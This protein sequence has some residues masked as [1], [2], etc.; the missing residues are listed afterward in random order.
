MFREVN[1]KSKSE[2]RTQEVDINVFEGLMLGYPSM[3]GHKGD[4]RQVLRAFK[5][6]G[7]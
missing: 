1:R 4:S 2:S 5:V 3:F 6:S 7:N